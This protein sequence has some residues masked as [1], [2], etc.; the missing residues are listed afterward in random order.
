MILIV[1]YA[2]AIYALVL[3][4]INEF[5]DYIKKANDFLNAL[6]NSLSLNSSPKIKTIIKH[7]IK[8]IALCS[9]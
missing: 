3:Q 8:L 4:Q 5:V 1:R 9:S 7:L 2:W 6:Q